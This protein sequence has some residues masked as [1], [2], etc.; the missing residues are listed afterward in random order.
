[1]VLRNV[2]LFAWEC[3]VPVLGEQGRQEL[4]LT[5]V[6]YKIIP[7]II[8]VSGSTF[9]LTRSVVFPLMHHMQESF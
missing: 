3:A 8:L 2:Q 9:V 5:I 1:M 6:I 4:P 7:L